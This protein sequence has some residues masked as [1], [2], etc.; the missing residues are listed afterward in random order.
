MRL[1]GRCLLLCSLAWPAEAQ[2]GA[3]LVY[4]AQNHIANL[5]QAARE[6]IVIQNQI[7]D[8]AS[9]TDMASYLE[10]AQQ[11]ADLVNEIQRIAGPLIQRYGRW[12]QLLTDV[13]TICNIYRLNVWTRAYDAE[14]AQ[15]FTDAAS[16]KPEFANAGTALRTLVQA[17]QQIL[18]LRGTVAGLQTLNGLVGTLLTR[19]VAME[20]A[21]TMFHETVQRKELKEML[22][23]RGMEAVLRAQRLALRGQK[24]CS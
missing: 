6:L 14:S 22:E 4:D 1:L 9:L 24:A 5:L 23:E 17:I 10:L 19:T 18:G 13:N 16:A 7:Q 21:N 3:S 20:A 12:T 2:V 15:A 11:A 8:L